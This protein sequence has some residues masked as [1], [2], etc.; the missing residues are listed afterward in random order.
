[1]K[2]VVAVAGARREREGG[3][4]DSTTE[5]RTDGRTGQR[6]GG[7][8]YGGREGGT[9]ADAAAAPLNCGSNSFLKQQLVTRRIEVSV[10]ERARWPSMAQA[11]AERPSRASGAYLHCVNAGEE[12]EE[13]EGKRE[14]VSQVG[15]PSVDG[16]RDRAACP[17]R[18]YAVAVA[19]V[20]V[21]PK[22][23][24]QNITA[25]SLPTLLYRVEPPNITRIWINRL[26]G[27]AQAVWQF[28]LFPVYI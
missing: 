23:V 16:E 7:Q 14:Q 11:A 26:F 10:C 25:G 17:P 5:E 6:A 2:Q 21:A 4:G 8:I 9:D 20:A 27:Q 24:F 19:A 15:H 3:K 12:E 13:E 22:A 1:M 28:F 18:Y